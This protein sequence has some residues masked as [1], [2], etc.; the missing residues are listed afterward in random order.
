[1]KAKRYQND[2]AASCTPLASCYILSSFIGTRGDIFNFFEKSLPP[3]LYVLI[4]ILL[5]PIRKYPI[6][7]I[8][9][10]RI[11][12]TINKIQPK[13]DPQ[14]RLRNAVYVLLCL[15]GKFQQLRFFEFQ[16]FFIAFP[17]CLLPAVDRIRIPVTL[18]GPIVKSLRDPV[19]V[20]ATIGGS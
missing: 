11:T 4:R 6:H 8:S 5:V 19:T 15:R 3:L 10:L 1:M 12:Q 20:S 9:Y 13:H 2:E 17:G 7:P 14:F 16:E 18:I